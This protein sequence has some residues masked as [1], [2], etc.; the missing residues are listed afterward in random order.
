MRQKLSGIKGFQTIKEE[1]ESIGLAKAIEQ[2]YYNY[3]PHEFPPLVAWESID[4]LGRA[5][6]LVNML[7][8]DH[9]ELVKTVIE[10]CKASG[11][12]FALLCTNTVDMVMEKLHDEGVLTNK[13]KSYKDGGY[14][15]LDEDKRNAVNE[16][17]EEICIATCLLSLSSNEKFGASKQELKNDLVKGKDNYSITISGVMNFL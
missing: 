8:T 3:Q 14:F 12:S 4:R 6:Q 1:A 2:I 16:R 5:I 10:V 17:A 9:Y 7:E 11:V 13:P 15:E